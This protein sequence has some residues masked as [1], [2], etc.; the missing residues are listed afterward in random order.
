MLHTDDPEN[1]TWERVEF[2]RAMH[3]PTLFF[4]DP[5]DG[6]PYVFYGNGNQT[7]VKLDPDNDWEIVEEYPD[8]FRQS[9]YNAEWTKGLFEGS[10][11]AYIDGMYYMVMITS[12]SGWARQVLMLRSPFLLGRYDDRSGGENT[13][14]DHCGLNSNGYAQGSLVEVANADGST[15]WHGFFFRDTYPGGRI[16]ALIPATWP[17]Q[18]AEDSDAEAGGEPENLIVNGSF[19][20]CVTDGW[21]TESTATLE[22]IEVSDSNCALSVS[23]RVNNGSGPS[24]DIGAKV[25]AGEKYKFEASFK[26]EDVSSGTLPETATFQMMLK[27]SPNVGG[28]D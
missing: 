25:L 10:Q 5:N 26:Y 2:G 9:D 13:Y 23:E 18:D 16:P 1:G 7:A 12:G 15:T 4:D 8:I 28:L 6:A 14:E 19:D 20:T 3:D 24:Q 27:G 22:A 21:D 17:D 11:L